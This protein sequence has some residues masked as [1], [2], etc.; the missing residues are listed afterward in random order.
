MWLCTADPG[1]LIYPSQASLYSSLQK[2]W[3]F[4]GL[5]AEAGRSIRCQHNLN[6]TSQYHDY[7]QYSQ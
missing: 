2:T 1:W 5:E 6:D 7:G 3:F 4:I